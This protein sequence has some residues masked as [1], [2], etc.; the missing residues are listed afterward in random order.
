MIKNILTGVLV[1]MLSGAAFAQSGAY[2]AASQSQAR[3]DFLVAAEYYFQAAQKEEFNV[4]LLGRALE[5]FVLAGNLDRAFELADVLQT[6]GAAIGNSRLVAFVG[7][8]KDEN[9]TAAMDVLNSGTVSTP[10]LDM[11]L[12]AWG[13]LAL[14]DQDAAFEKFEA[15]SQIENLAPVASLHKI[16]A[17]AQAG[18]FD[19]AV[20]E[21]DASGP[22][23]GSRNGMTYAQ[24]LSNSDRMEDALVMAK[25][26]PN[27]P[28]LSAA[29]EAMTKEQKLDFDTVV[30]PTEGIAEILFTVAQSQEEVSEAGLIYGRLATALVGANAQAHL[31]VAQNLRDFRAYGLAQNSFKNIAAEDPYH[32]RA[33]LGLIDATWRDG[34]TTAATELARALVD[35]YPDQQEAHRQLGNLLRDQEDYRGA[36]KSYR[37]AIKLIETPAASDWSLYYARA[38]TFERRGKWRKAER[39]F[40]AALELQP[41]QYRVLNYLGYSLVE[42]GEKLDEALSMIERAVAQAPD[43]G[44][45]ADSLGWALFKLGQYERALDP[46]EKAV[47]LMATD[48]VVNDHLGDVYWAVGRK[49][50]AEFQWLRTLSFITEDTDLRDIDPERVKSKLDLGLDAVLKNEGASP[51]K[52]A[53]EN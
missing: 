22:F 53:D 18:D 24:V 9:F 37:R 21:Y 4:R 48:P 51:L 35:A 12:R 32:F 13:H 28:A 38:I 23:G 15:V 27:D 29:V 1:A 10:D 14:G 42:R 50:E 6:N 33:Q 39:D 26:F 16:L 40:R 34:K 41:D 52:A 25:R 7:Q 31:L 11:F 30:S 19:K 46:M 47:S 44:Y 45:I 43:A 3:N 5:S 2:L 17:H 36:E 49:P 8:V 20:I